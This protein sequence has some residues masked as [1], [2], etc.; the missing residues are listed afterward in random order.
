LS[1]SHLLQKDKIRIYKIILP[2]FLHV[3]KT[4]VTLREENRLHILENKVFRDIFLSKKNEAGYYTRGE[5]IPQMEEI[6]NVH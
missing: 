3:A 2:V 5:Y 6:R 1:S 4:S